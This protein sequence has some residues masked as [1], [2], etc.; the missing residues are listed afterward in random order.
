[1]KNNIHYFDVDPDNIT[2]AGWSGD[3]AGVQ[4]DYLIPFSRKFIQKGIS[5]LEPI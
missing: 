3:G 2:I 5:I 4:F 1:M